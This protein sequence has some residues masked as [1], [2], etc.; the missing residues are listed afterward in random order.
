MYSRT[1]LK[2]PSELKRT[3]FL[4]KG[5]NHVEQNCA[6][7]LLPLNKDNPHITVKLH[8]NPLDSMY[9]L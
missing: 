1:S 2:G 7:T 4:Y 3:Q 6:N 9:P 8:Q 5:L